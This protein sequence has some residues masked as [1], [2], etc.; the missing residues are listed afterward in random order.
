MPYPLW[1]FGLL[2]AIPFVWIWLPIMVLVYA[3]DE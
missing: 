1:A 2:L 3:G